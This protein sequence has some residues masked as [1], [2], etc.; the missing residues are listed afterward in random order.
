MSGVAPNRSARSASMWR[1]EKFLARPL[2][3]CNRTILSSKWNGPFLRTVLTCK[4]LDA[5]A[6]HPVD[7]ELPNEARG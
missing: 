1:E 6:S 2:R 4:R 3:I 5:L 7:E